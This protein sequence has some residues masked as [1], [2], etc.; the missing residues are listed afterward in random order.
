MLSIYYSF[1]FPARQR[2]AS[3]VD[4]NPGSLV[5]AVCPSAS[6]HGIL[7]VSGRTN[8]HS[9]IVHQVLATQGI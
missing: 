7:D 9:S 5:S 8:E 6:V 3:D 2:H 4:V 1:R